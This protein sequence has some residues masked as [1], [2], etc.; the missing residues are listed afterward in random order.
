MCADGWKNGAD[1][2]GQC[3]HCN[4]DVDCDGNA[5]SGCHWSQICD[6]CGGAPCDL[7]C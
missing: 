2:A 7:S 5:V 1:V 4:G 3:A 6:V